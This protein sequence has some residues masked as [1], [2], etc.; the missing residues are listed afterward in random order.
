ME[1]S[2]E[3]QFEEELKM[4]SRNVEGNLTSGATFVL[5]F[6]KSSDA[7]LMRLVGLAQK[8]LGKQFEKILWIFPDVHLNLKKIPTFQKGFQALTFQG[9]TGFGTVRCRN[10]YGGFCD[11]H[12]MLEKMSEVFKNCWGKY[13]HRENVVEQDA[14]TTA[15][16]E[17]CCMAKVDI[18][19]SLR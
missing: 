12:V 15:L 5:G 6:L 4:V 19:H 9:N 8:I 7:R 16:V 2:N 13:L 14:N 18:A 1:S 11:F 3:K 10:N 17:E